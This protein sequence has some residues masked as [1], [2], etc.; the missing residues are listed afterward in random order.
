M[1]IL[2]RDSGPHSGLHPWGK[3]AGPKYAWSPSVGI[4]ED[5]PLIIAWRLYTISFVNDII[6]RGANPSVDTLY[7][8]GEAI[9]RIQAEVNQ[10]SEKMSNE[11]ILT[12]LSVGM[13]AVSVLFHD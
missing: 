8:Q 4:D 3:W 13:I 10:P 7:Y 11:L 2:A 1:E 6:N 9:R 5:N 12:M